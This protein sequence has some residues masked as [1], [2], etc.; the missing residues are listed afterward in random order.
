MKRNYQSGMLVGLII[1][2][3]IM[4]TIVLC[5]VAKPHDKIKNTGIEETWLRYDI[6]FETDDEFVKNFEI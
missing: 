6:D 2:V 3:L 1:G 4:I 5:A